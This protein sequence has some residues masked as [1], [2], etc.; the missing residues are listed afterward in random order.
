MIG[1]ARD[2]AMNSS[3]R[4]RSRK[5]YWPGLGSGLPE[6][7]PMMCWFCSIGTWPRIPWA[8]SRTGSAALSALYWV[9]VTPQRGQSSTAGGGSRL[10]AGSLGMGLA[11]SP[12][13]KSGL[14]A[15]LMPA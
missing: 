1:S 8:R 2:D 7:Q 5:L 10:G 3:R 12:P 6:P 15:V 14:D 9:C 4:L 11:A 13:L